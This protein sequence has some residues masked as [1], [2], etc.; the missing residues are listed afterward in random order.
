MTILISIK[1][2]FS[3]LIFSQEKKYEFRKTSINAQSNDFVFVYESA[4]TKAI[5][6]YFKIE[7]IIKKSPKD[8]WNSL[9]NNINI[10]ER[11]FFEYFKQK[12]WGY[13]IKISNPKLFRKK[14]VL[15]KLRELYGSWNPP[16]NFRY[17]REIIEQNFF[18]FISFLS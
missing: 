7:K 18:L 9:K 14:L 10:S 5:V 2:K 17:L 6:G 16:Q 15:K 8:I 3:Q 12:K 13:A 4:P 11:E 1:P